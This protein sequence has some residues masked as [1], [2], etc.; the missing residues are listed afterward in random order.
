VR[1]TTSVRC[2]ITSFSGR[3]TGPESISVVIYSGMILTDEV[4]K[5]ELLLRYGYAMLI[6]GKPESQMAISMSL[7]SITAHFG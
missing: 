5:I 7:A 1:D 4:I 2:E 6:A 3:K